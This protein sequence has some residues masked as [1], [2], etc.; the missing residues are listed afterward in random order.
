MSGPKFDRYKMEKSYCCQC[1]SPIE[2]STATDFC[3]RC[4]K[5]IYIPSYK[6]LYQQR[7][8]ILL[9]GQPEKTKVVIWSLL[10]RIGLY[11]N[12]DHDLDCLRRLEDI[13]K[14][15]K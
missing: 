6:E 12:D 9:E 13:L 7:F 2:Y 15:L 14:G 1:E 3:Q 8:E 11:C 10:K 5:P 4:E